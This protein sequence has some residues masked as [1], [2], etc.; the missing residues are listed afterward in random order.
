MTNPN[1]KSKCCAANL[2]IR[3]EEG[4]D[5][6]NLLMVTRCTKCKQHCPVWE[7]NPNPF[8][9]SHGLPAVSAATHIPEK[10]NCELCQFEEGHAQTCPKYKPREWKEPQKDWRK[11]FDSLFTGN[12]S[13]DSE[14]FNDLY[15]SLHVLPL[16]KSFISKKIAEAEE[17]ERREAFEWVLTNCHGG[18]DF[19]RK[20]MQRLSEMK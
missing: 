12:F 4:N 15:L 18:G 9:L 14:P 8:A 13:I 20:V 3:V 16:L 5:P 7:E 6:P 17:R 11:E 2:S 1:Q 19:R 10:P